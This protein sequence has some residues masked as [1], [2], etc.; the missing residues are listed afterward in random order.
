QAV[1]SGTSDV[2]VAGGV[3]NMSAVPIAFAMTAAQSLGFDDP[4]SGS[5]GWRKRYGDQEVSQFRAAEMIAEKWSLT[6]EVMEQF[7]VRSH[8]RALL[9]RSEG[10]FDR[11]IVP[12]FGLAKEG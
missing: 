6:R 7:A 5:V 11:E 10:R 3:Q 2:V 9:A 12:S 1:L 8:E 4:F